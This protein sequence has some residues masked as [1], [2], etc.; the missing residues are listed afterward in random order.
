MASIRN[1]RRRWLIGGALSALVAG[2]ALWVTRHPDAQSSPDT[3]APTT[4]AAAPSPAAPSTPTTAARPAEPAQSTNSAAAVRSRTPARL[5]GKPFAPSLADTDIDGALKADANGQL[6]IDLGTRDFFDYFLSTVGEVSPDTAIGQIQTLAQTYLPAQ[7]AKQA[8]DLLDQYLAY[9]QASLSLLQA[10]LDPALS[11]DPDYQLN[12]LGNALAGLKELRSETFS[13]RAHEAFF[14]LEE[15][16]SEYTLNAMAIARRTDLS[17]SGKEALIEYQ[18]QQLPEVIRNTEVR[19]QAEAATQQ[20]RVAA[21][22]EA[23]SPEAAGKR[24]A[25][26]GLD[27]EGVQGVVTYLQQRKRFDERFQQFRQA[28]SEQ[29]LSGLAPADRKRQQ[30]ALLQEYFPDG[31][32]Q[33]WARLK[34]LDRG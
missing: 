20:A 15:A 32:A 30:D 19:M 5:D 4:Q 17:D 33:T 24:L 21:I 9:K 7:A 28:A 13:A 25:E 18:R 11:Q 23:D 6:V 27:E 14:G 1:R 3:A 8:M 16:Y 2:S 34:L 29:S 22:K 31:Q 10:K 26:L 12:A